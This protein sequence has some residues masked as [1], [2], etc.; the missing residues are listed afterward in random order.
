MALGCDDL[1]KDAGLS[2]DCCDSCHGEWEGGF[3]EPDDVEY[4][5]KVYFV[6]CA[7]AISLMQS[8][9]G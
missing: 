9:K 3:T 2:F 4:Q 7:G 6:C 1:R 8:G 5:G